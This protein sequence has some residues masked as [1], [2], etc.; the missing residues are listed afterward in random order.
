MK[1]FSFLTTIFIVFIFSNSISAQAEMSPDEMAIQEVLQGIEDAWAAKDGEQ[2][3]AYF[4]NDHDFIVWT[5]MYFPNINQATN[6]RN[7]Q[8]IFNSIYKNWDVTLRVDKT[9]FIRPDLALVHV[10]GAGRDKGQ[11]IPPYPNVIQSVLMEKTGASWQI[12]SFHNLDIEYE[13]NLRKNFPTEV[14]KVVYAK[15]HYKGWYK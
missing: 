7:H 11:E 15:K 14:D 1:S 4:A 12:I 2:F 13:S 3:A 9:R 10:L 5:G 8:G 6:A